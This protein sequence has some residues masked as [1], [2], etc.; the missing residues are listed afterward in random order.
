MSDK[1]S[2]GGGFNCIWRK[3]NITFKDNKMTLKI[4]KEPEGSSKP[5]SGGEY[6]TNNTYGYGYYSVP[7][8]IMMN[9]WPGNYPGWLKP[10]DKIIDLYDLISISRKI[11]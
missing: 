9:V 1:W 2:N 4:D 8:R 5:F 7:G 6:A 10:F 11:T 3:D